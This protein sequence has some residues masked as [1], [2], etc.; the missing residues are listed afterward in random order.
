MTGLLLILPMVTSAQ[1]TNFLHSIEEIER[2]IL[3][4]EF[5]LFRYSDLRFD[6][7][8]SK[9]AILKFPDIKYMQVKWRRA[10]EGA[11]EFNNNPRFEM[12]AY[13]IQKLF[14]DEN[15]FVVPPTLCKIYPFAQYLGMEPHAKPTFLN[16]DLVLVLIQYWL[17]E[18]SVDDV[19]D[20]RRLKKDSL[21]AGYFA[22]LNILTYLIRH[23]DS[24]KG[25]ILIS[26]DQTNPRVFAV[27]NGVAFS[28]QHSDRGTEWRKLHV[29]KFPAKTVERLRAITSDD[30]IRALSVVAQF[31][32]KDGHM[33]P[34]PAT[35]SLNV[36]KG[37]RRIVNRI[38]LGLTSKEIRDVEERLQ[39]LLK[40]IDEGKYTVF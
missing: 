16:P 35:E 22:N 32:M 37:V 33:T 27:D 8:I 1:D 2:R 40:K 30:L 6:G 36:D 11:D 9:R 10:R 13:Q 4:E 29:K 14:L 38:Q 19:F 25:N 23:S 12:S 39:Y 26:K 20:K 24:N 34:V 3:H 21:Y 17:E 15:E 7:D 28:S 18:V 5:E 31:E